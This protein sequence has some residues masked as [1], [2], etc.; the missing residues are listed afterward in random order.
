MD[1]G[2]AILITVLRIA[3]IFAGIVWVGVGFTLAMYFKPVFDAAGIDSRKFM[4]ALYTKT[5]FDKLMP[6]VSMITTLAGIILYGLIMSFNSSFA[7]SSQGIVLGIGA[8][9][10]LAAAGHGG[11]VLG[12]RGAEYQ[13]L[14]K[15]AGDTPTGA[16]QQQMVEMEDFLLKHAR[17]SMWMMV[18]AVVGM[19]GA[20]YVPSILGG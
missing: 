19:A 14:V 1:Q 20:R 8:L 4:R 5:A 2:T 15:E 3:H 9:A 12:R 6:I 7:S 13:S 18:V 10:G 11:A 16:Q 17:I